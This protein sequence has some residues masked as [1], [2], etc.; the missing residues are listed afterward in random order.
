MKRFLQ[1]GAIGILLALAGGWWWQHRA[2]LHPDF[3]RSWLSQFGVWAPFL[4]AILYAANTVTLLPPIGVLSLTAGLAFGPVVGFLAIMAGAMIGTSATFWIG[5]RLGREFVERKLKGRLESLNENLS[6][7]GFATILF[8]RLVPIVPYEMLNYAS[9]LSKIR[10]R[11][12]SLASLLGFLPGAAIAAWFGDSLTQPFSWKFVLG[13][14]GLAVLIAIPALYI[15]R[16]RKIDGADPRDK[17]LS[18]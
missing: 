11:D 3:F 12:Y 17:N 6:S 9:G 14:G 10:F 18:S 8:F 16:R 15:K 5:R 1:W 7:K 13:L 4:Y 2:I